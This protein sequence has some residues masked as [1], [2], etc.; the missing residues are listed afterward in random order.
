MNQ[1]PNNQ[2]ESI[3]EEKQTDK[4]SGVSVSVPFSKK[5]ENFI[6]YYKWHTL[7]AIL[8]IFAVVICTFQMCTRVDANSAI[9]QVG[10]PSLN[11]TQKRLLTKTMQELTDNEDYHTNFVTYAIA[12]NADVEGLLNPNDK[13]YVQKLSDDNRKTFE[14]ELATGEAYICLFSPHAYKL[15][16]S[17]FPF[18]KVTDE[19]GKVSY[20][21]RLFR[22]ISEFTDSEFPTVDSDG[23]AVYL[24]DTPLRDLPGFSSMPNDTILCMR[25]FGYK[26]SR[27]DDAK[28]TYLEQEKLF[29]IMLN[30]TDE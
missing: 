19:E 23:Y 9:M 27:E 25:R 11:D 10:Y 13:A 14:L 3:G 4:L 30:Y 20:V 5:W 8:V 24:R 26:L 21:S 28:K 1:E 16:K 15:A 29:R 2:N 12:S 6:Y 22:P 7:A 17:S 18:D